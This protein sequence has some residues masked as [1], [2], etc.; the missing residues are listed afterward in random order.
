MIE[1]RLPSLGADMDEGKL[2]EWRIRPGDVVKK[3]QV[4]CIVDTA[5]AAIDVE[6]WHDGTVQRLLVEPGTT[7]PVGTAMAVLREAGESEAEVEHQIAPAAVAPAAA[8]APASQAPRAVPPPAATAAPAGRRRISP[9]SAV[10]R[11][12]PLPSA[13]RSSRRRAARR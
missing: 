5:K 4:V 10:A 2:L 11:R 13:S 1:F 8:T 3:G 12:W 6:C 7:I 9:A